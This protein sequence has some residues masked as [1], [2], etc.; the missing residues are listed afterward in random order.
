MIMRDAARYYGG[1]YEG[2]LARNDTDDLRNSDTQIHRL[3]LY[4]LSL[5]EETGSWDFA[6]QVMLVY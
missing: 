6:E 1:T 5:T 2:Y 3:D 4:M